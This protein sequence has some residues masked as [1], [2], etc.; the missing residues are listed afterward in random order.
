MARVV[1]TEFV[2]IDGVA[3]DPGGSEGKDFGGWAFEFDRGAEGDAFKAEEMEP[4]DAMLLGR[5]TYEGFAEAWPSREGEYADMFNSMKK[6]VVSSTLTDPEWTNTEVLAGDL[7]E[8]VEG[9]RSKH[10]GDIV[11]HGSLQLARELIARGLVDELRLMVFPTVIGA[12]KRL[13]GEAD[14]P[15]AMELTESK[16]AAETLCLV[17]RPK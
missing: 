2:T 14:S 4:A 15:V 3:E 10:D 5:N 8:A 9:I 1:I 7:G 17:Y 13:F 6:Y 12:G 11:V 16:P